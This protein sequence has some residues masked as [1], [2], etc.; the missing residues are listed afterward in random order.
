MALSAA[1]C[2][3]SFNVTTEEQ[4]LIA[5]YAAHTL[6]KHSKQSSSLLLSRSDL[7]KA[8]AVKEEQDR[9]VAERR[10]ERDRYPASSA[11]SSAASGSR[12]AEG[13]S[14]SDEP[15]S[16]SSLSPQVTPEQT[17]V[18][19][20]EAVGVSGLSFEYKGY[21]VMEYIQGAAFSVNASP[22]KELVVMN[23]TVTNN[24][25]ADVTCDLK[26]DKTRFKGFF[27]GKAVS[28]L[29]TAFLPN[30][31]AS[32][33][34]NTKIG[35]KKK[36]DCVLVFDVPKDLAESLTDVRLSVTKNGESGSSGVT[37]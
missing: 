28:A 35:A 19:M 9:K 34:K 11:A 3:K 20:T 13:S 22:G 37:I 10:A 1:G 17:N 23:F 21:D 6:V 31:I 26:T 16:G 15:G 2:A 4:M 32:F 8:I 14:E 12:S 29:S 33:D 24:T 25:D 5:E 18:S 30:D 36:E 27:N 7:E